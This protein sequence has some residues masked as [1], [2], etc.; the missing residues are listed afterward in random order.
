MTCSPP[1]RC[2]HT[3]CCLLPARGSV[4]ACIPIRLGRSMGAFKRLPG[5]GGEGKKTAPTTGSLGLQSGRQ[6]KRS[7]CRR[8]SDPNPTVTPHVVQ[9]PGPL[10]TSHPREEED[11]VPL[12][13]TGQVPSSQ[14]PATSPLYAQSAPALCPGFKQGRGTQLTATRPHG[15]FL[16]WDHRRGAEGP[17]GGGGVEGPLQAPDQAGP[18]SPQAF[19]K[20]EPQPPA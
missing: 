16:Q 19:R 2:P 20:A 18:P 6:G 5:V 1:A 9:R 17:G 14:P 10:S 12:L 3:S 7:G 13:H 11:G 8:G 15:C 4:F